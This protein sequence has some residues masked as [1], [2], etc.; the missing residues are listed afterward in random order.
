MTP[1]F[2]GIKS[3]IVE[4]DTPNRLQDHQCTCT[5]GIPSLAGK[6]AFIYGTLES[7][8]GARDTRKG[9]K[10]VLVSLVILRF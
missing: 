10:L 8:S 9:G 6:R 3:K 1:G 5:G 4:G 2:P 7:A